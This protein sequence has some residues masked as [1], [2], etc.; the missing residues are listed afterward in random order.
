[1]QLI[2]CLT[3]GSQSFIDSTTSESSGPVYTCSTYEHKRSETFSPLQLFR[4]NAY[5]FFLFAFFFNLSLHVSGDV[6]E[7]SSKT[8]QNKNEICLWPSTVSSQS[9][10]T[11]WSIIYL[12]R[13]HIVM[14]FSTLEVN[15]SNLCLGSLFRRRYMLNT[16]IYESW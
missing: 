9:Q 16:H 13:V 4:A 3:S 12:Y 10:K 1:M 14:T 8:Q 2:T 15:N 11:L 7:K 6:Y 5:E